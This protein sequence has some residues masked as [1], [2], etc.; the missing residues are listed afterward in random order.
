MT[1]ALRVLITGKLRDGVSADDFRRFASEMQA[2]VAADEPGT[3]VYNWWIGE[4]G[5]V[6][7][8]DGYADEASFAAHMGAMTESGNLDKWMSMVE[9]Q[10][11]Q[12]LG[13]ASDAAREMAAGFGAVHYSLASKR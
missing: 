6:I 9:P 1:V 8:E 3:T 4:N 7:N 2:I 10:S 12:V 5:T 11:V 13:D